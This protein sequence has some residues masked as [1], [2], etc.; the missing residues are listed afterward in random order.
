MLFRSN[1]HSI[2]FHRTV[3]K[4]DMLWQLNNLIGLKISY[5]PTLLHLPTQLCAVKKTFCFPCPVGYKFER[6]PLTLQ[7]KSVNY[8]CQIKWKLV[9]ACVYVRD[10]GLGWSP[11]VGE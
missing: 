10:W 2:F 11:M 9:F 1:R 4:A 6:A 7:S 8:K 5:A 3:I